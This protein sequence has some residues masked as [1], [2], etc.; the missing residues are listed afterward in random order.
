[1]LQGAYYADRRDSSLSSMSSTQCTDSSLNRDRMSNLQAVYNKPMR[2]GSE[3]LARSEDISRGVSLTALRRHA[4]ARDDGYTDMCGV[5]SPEKSVP[6]KRFN[7]G[8]GQFCC[9]RCESNFTRPKSVKDHFPYCV[10]KCGNPGALRYTDHPSMAQTEAA[11]QRR[12][13]ASRESSS[14]GLEEMNK[15]LY[16]NPAHKRIGLATD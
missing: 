16:A 12:A 14:V 7:L 8:K 15:A 2:T 6:V 10:I 5:S 4:H 3:S 9:P 11:I 13:R 1:M